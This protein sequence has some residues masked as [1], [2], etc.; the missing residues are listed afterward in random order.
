MS[1]TS[2]DGTDDIFIS[3]AHVDNE[4]PKKGMDGW[5]TRF[6]H[7]L[8]VRVAQVRGQ[9]P[10]IFRDPKLQGNDVFADVLMDRIQQS[11]ILVSILSPRYLK[12]EWCA[13]E[14]TEFYAQQ[15]K[16]GTLVVGDHKARVFKIVKTSIPL[17]KLPKEVQ[18]LIGYDF[19]KLDEK[20][21]PQE[22]DEMYGP[23]AEY[24]FWARL[25]D[26]AYDIAQ[27]LDLI[28]TKPEAASPKPMVYLAETISELQDERDAIRRDLQRHGYT[29]LPDRT[30]PLLMPELEAVLRDEMARCKV[31]VHLLG[32]AYGIVPEG[33]EESLTIVQNRIA[34][35]LGK[36]G[37]LARLIW[38]E[39]N[40]DGKDARQ[41][42]FL[43]QAR[44]DPGLDEGADVL[45]TPLEE[46]KTVLYERLKAAEQ[47]VVTAPPPAAMSGAARI[48]LV[49]DARDRE[50]VKP[51]Q[52]QLK[53]QGCKVSL[54]LF[55]GDEAELRED[56]EDNLRF[57][58]AVLIYYG[59]GSEAW[60]R[61]KMREVIGSMAFGR[62]A[63]LAAVGIVLGAPMTDAKE[64]F[65]S[66][67][68]IVMN[69]LEAF[70]P[71]N[72]REFLARL[73]AARQSEVV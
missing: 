64:D 49:C 6:H 28:E 43:E 59:Q 3:Y 71:D 60:Q 36:A 21:R 8:E 47:P 4:S 2:P 50:A 63:P 24:A 69:M 14:L 72:L 23:D 13:R 46:L 54:P 25:N 70:A 32:P 7:A 58:D 18:E 17:D 19:F 37:K 10:K 53:Q 20:G 52:Q 51:L 27:L 26:L 45:E 56:H 44:T 67:D 65:S 57:C 29:V 33:T 22:L 73:Q 48:Y 40:S 35:D 30:L 1:S 31:S 39:A 9:R 5:I 16:A 55:E 15:Q 42:R 68:A 66:D 11:G 12:S 62:K 61:K 41:T 34:R 38:I